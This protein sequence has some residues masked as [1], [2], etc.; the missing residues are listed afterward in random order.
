MKHVPKA[1]ATELDIV[2]IFLKDSDKQCQ[3]A[4]LANEPVDLDKEGV[5]KTVKKALALNRSIVPFASGMGAI[6]KA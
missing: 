3:K 2:T 1:T 6:D 5:E 4:L